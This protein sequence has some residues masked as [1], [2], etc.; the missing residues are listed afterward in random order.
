MKSEARTVCLEINRATGLAVATDRR[1]IGQFDQL[2][3]RT[4]KTKTSQ[5]WMAPA[6]N[7]ARQMTDTAQRERRGS[8][9]PTAFGGE[10]V[11]FLGFGR[12]V[13]LL[14]GL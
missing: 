2:K 7:H 8:A 9:Y 13:D 11:D 4:L 3:G 6:P 12:E 10:E 5:G 14:V 1:A